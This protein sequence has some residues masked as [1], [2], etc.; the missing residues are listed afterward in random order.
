MNWAT[1]GLPELLPST[2]FRGFGQSLP[3]SVYIGLAVL[4]Q[5][6]REN[7]AV[8]SKGKSQWRILDF[9]LITVS[10]FLRARRRSWIAL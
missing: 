1:Q 2:V 10:R 3:G 5:L 6:A 9:A 4:S 7:I 8:K